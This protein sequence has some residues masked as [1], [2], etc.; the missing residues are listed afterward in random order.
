MTKRGGFRVAICGLAVVLAGCS[1]I[2][3]AGP[4]AMEITA[5]ERPA[6]AFDG[7]IVVDIDQ[8]VASILSHQPFPSLYGMFRDRRPRPDLRIGVG[9][10]LTV[11]IWE[12]AA[13]GLFS[14]ATVDRVSPGLAHRDYP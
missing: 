14:S 4:T 8:R 7:Y 5:Q 11:T 2:P 9:D 13:G 12:A 1:S 10:G 6:G 3:S